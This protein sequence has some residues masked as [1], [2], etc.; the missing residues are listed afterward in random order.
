M[1]KTI[2]AIIAA[3]T[4]VTLAGCGSSNES[5][6]SG[7]VSSTEAVTSS[8]KTTTATSA[9]ETEP[10]EE[11][12]QEQ[13]A[14]EISLSG[15]YDKIITQQPEPENTVM[16]PESSEELINEF[17]PGLIQLDIKQM[18][19]YMPPVTG[20]ACEILLLET[21]DSGSADKAQKIMSDR[22][23]KA[24]SDTFYADVAD[25]W[26]RNAQVQRSGNRLCMIVLPD[27]AVIPDDVFSL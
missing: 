12:T 27:G 5:S 13:T 6:V 22:V 8:S 4:A 3:L 11:V 26:A 23:D 1:K 20:N 25:V 18:A 15:I 19:L 7:G 10:Q 9:A 17:Y 16:F 2:F 14:Q 24:A 21:V